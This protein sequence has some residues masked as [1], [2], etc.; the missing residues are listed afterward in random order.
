[1]IENDELLG[2]GRTHLVKEVNGKRI[3]FFGVAGQ[4]WL[5]ILGDDYEDELVY[6]DVNEFS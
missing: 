1:M 2:K 4:D 3:G 5:G 6:E